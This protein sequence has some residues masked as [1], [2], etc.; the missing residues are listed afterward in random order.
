VSENEKQATS[1]VDMWQLWDL[2]PRPFGPA[3]EAGALDRSAKLSCQDTNKA[4]LANNIFAINVRFQDN[5]SH[6]LETLTTMPPK[7]LKS[8]TNG[9][10]K[11]ILLRCD[12]AGPLPSCVHVIVTWRL[13]GLSRMSAHIVE[14]G[15]A[16]AN[17]LATS[18]NLHSIPQLQDVHKFNVLF[19]PAGAALQGR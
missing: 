19:W 10:A 2:N 7:R 13:N 6:V 9:I 18:V 1:Q 12:V 8:R 16:K 17:W 5:S 3:P 4:F 11:T 14:W 15:W